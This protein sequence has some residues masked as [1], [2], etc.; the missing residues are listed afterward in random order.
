M[1]DGELMTAREQSLNEKPALIRC[2]G[3]EE[4]TMESERVMR[5]EHSPHPCD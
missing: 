1:V 5:V 4:R 2:A 3:F